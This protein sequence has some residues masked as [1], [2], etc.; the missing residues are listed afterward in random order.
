MFYIHGFHHE[1]QLQKLGKAFKLQSQQIAGVD[2]WS[3]HIEAS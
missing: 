2:D 1:L 3:Y